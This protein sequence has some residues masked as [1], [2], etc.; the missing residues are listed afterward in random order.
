MLRYMCTY[1]IDGN[2]P[3]SLQ[4]FVLTDHS[5]GAEML[6]TYVEWQVISLQVCI[7]WKIVTSVLVSFSSE[8]I[9][10]LG[11]NTEETEKNNFCHRGSNSIGL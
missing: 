1:K 9:I 3:S 11:K 7:T 8:T 6:K 10:V 5:N 4:T 2:F